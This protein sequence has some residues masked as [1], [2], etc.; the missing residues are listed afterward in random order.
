MFLYHSVNVAG[1]AFQ[2]CSFNHSDISP[3]RINN[4]QSRP[5]RI[6][7]IVIR[8]ECAAITYGFFKYTVAPQM[9]GGTA[10]HSAVKGRVRE[11][12]HLELWA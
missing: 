12:H 11:S 2:A 10:L 7:A 5:D 4:L 3:F 6:V 9:H 1:F 8:P